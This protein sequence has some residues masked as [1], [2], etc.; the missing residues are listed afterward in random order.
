MSDT[1]NIQEPWTTCRYAVVDVEGNGQ[2]PPDLVE[3]AIVPI[4]EGVIR[5]PRTWLV[6]PPRPITAMARG[7]HKITDAEVVSCPTVGE[8]ADEMREALAD[9]IFVAHNAHVDLGVLTR[10]LPGFEPTEVIDTLKLA[11]KLAPGQV[12]YRLGGLAETFCLADG[13]P[14]DLHA[15]RAAYDALVTARLLVR[16][17]T[18]TTAPL[19][20]ADPDLL[21]RVAR[22]GNAGDTADALF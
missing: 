21:T 14:Q 20:L 4:V 13:V 10:E 7:F 16:I 8:V 18:P 17:A 12:S 9:A 1:P 15:H 11:K 19:A 22:G 3:L 5:Q 6:K 2:Q